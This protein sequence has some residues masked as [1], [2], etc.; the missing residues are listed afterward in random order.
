MHGFLKKDKNGTFFS[1]IGLISIYPSTYNG[2]HFCVLKGGK[3][4]IFSLPVHAVV[5]THVLSNP[6]IPP[7]RPML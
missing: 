2:I 7:G 1:R 5:L 4:N 6:R 3:N